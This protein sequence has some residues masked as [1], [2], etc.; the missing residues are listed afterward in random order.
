MAL[1]KIVSTVEIGID[2]S[3]VF[4]LVIIT[5]TRFTAKQNYIQTK[6]SDIK[7]GKRNSKE[8]MK[9]KYNLTKQLINSV[10]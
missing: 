10:D 9:Y 1:P 3:Y 2:K 4:L 6:S 7:L 5:T 8:K